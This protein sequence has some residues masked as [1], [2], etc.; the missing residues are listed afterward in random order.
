[1]KEKTKRILAAVLVCC[2]ILTV[3]GGCSGSSASSTPGAAATVSNAASEETYTWRLQCVYSLDSMQGVMAKQIAEEL[4]KMTNGRL[5]IELYGPGSL[6][7]AADTVTYL[8]EG[9]FDMAVTFGSTFSGLIPE[10]DL[11][12][13]LPFA[14]ES[15]DE[16]FDAFEN[17]GLGDI[18]QEAYDELNIQWYWMAHEP[19]YNTLCNFKV[20]GIESYQG[21]KIRALGVWGDYYSKIGAS[22]VNIPGTEVYQALQLGTIDGAH[23]G[24]S[25]LKDANNIAEVVDYCVTPSAGHIAM[26]ILIN[27]DSLAALPEDLRNIVDETTR[28]AA[29]GL[30]SNTHVVTTKAGVYKALQAGEV[31]EIQLSDETILEMREAAVQVWDELAAKSDRMARGI[32]IIKQQSRDYG[33]QVDF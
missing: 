11:E 9:S 27:K 29:M 14:W 32:E 13:G 17:R 1:M 10:A 24:W 2:T 3:L 7:Q 23:Y 18:V 21:K 4:S 31:T 19:N 5:T 16:I 25:S 15:A 12:T 8:S 22:P 33:R 28:L 26:S 20:T 6:C 30:I